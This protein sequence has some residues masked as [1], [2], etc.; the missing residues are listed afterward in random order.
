M[1]RIHHVL[2]DGTQV[3]DI[4]GHVIKAEQFEV[5]YH[6]IDQ[7]NAKKGTKNAEKTVRA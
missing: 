1:I 6:V 2:K 5:L 7:I 4:S 3:D